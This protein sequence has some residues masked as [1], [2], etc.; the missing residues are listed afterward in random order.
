MWNIHPA[1]TRNNSKTFRVDY[2]HVF[3]CV[4]KEACDSSISLIADLLAMSLAF[5][6][7]PGLSTNASESARQPRPSA[8][9]PRRT[10]GDASGTGRRR[11]RP[12]D[13]QMSWTR[14]RCADWEKKTGRSPIKRNCFACIIIIA[15]DR[16]ACLRFQCV[17]CA[18][19]YASTC[20]LFYHVSTSTSHRSCLETVPCL[21]MSVLP[22]AHPRTRPPHPSSRA[23][24]QVAR[25]CVSAAA[26]RQVVGRGRARPVRAPRRRSA[27]AGG[28][29]GRGQVARGARTQARHR[30]THTT[31]T[32]P[33]SILPPPP[34]SRD[35]DAFCKVNLWFI[36]DWATLL[37]W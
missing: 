22:A 33:D 31:H 21:Y 27:T 32:A 5:R 7:D 18:F 20:L 3:H 2:K 4:F 35:C 28:G 34:R 6:F 30:H 23:S 37:L 19:I 15:F 9:R 10:S 29:R 36:E 8:R 16:I 26:G 25:L 24:G 17:L 14:A 11:R 1:L 13:A 12:N